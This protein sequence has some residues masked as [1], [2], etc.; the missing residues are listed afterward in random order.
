MADLKGK[1]MAHSELKDTLF[2]NA[3]QHVP[4]H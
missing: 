4:I 3:N 2:V 1:L